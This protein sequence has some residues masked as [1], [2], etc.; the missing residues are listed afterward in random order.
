MKPVQEAVEDRRED[1]AGGDENDQARV[2]RVERCEYFPRRSLDRIHRTHAAEDHRGV[3]QRVDPGE[4][5]QK[6][7]A[8]NTDRERTGD[9]SQRYADM[10]AKPPEELRARQ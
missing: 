8:E 10:A 5:F 4:L 2:E 7:I 1:D 9:E 3:Q 6:V